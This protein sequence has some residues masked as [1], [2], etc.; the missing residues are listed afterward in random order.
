MKRNTTFKIMSHLSARCRSTV[1]PVSQPNA[2]RIWKSA[3]PASALVLALLL[4]AMGARAVDFHCAT[5]Q[6]LQNALT[7][8]AANGANNNIYVTN[9]Y[10]IG[11]FNYNSSAGYNLTVTNEP[12]V[13]NTQITLDGAGGGRALSLTSSGTGTITVAGLTFSRNCGSTSIGALRIAG[14]VGSVILVNGC[15]FLS[16]TNT[17]GIGLEL[18]S[19]LNATVTNCIV[20]GSS[21]GGITFGVS[22][23]GV[24]GNVSLLNC[25]VTTNSDIGVSISGALG[26]TISGNIFTGNI[27]RFASGYGGGGLFCSGTTVTL[28]RNTFVGNSGGF[29]GGTGQPD[30]GGAACSGTTITLNYNTFIGNSDTDGYG[31][32]AS[33]KGTT[34][35]LSN[36]AF[37]NNSGI[38]GGGFWCYGANGN[39]SMYNNTFSGNTANDGGG[40]I[41]CDCNFLT[42]IGNIF[43]GN[44]TIHNNGNANF[45]QNGGGINIQ[46]PYNATIISNTFTGNSASGAGGGLYF[47]GGKLTLSANTIIQNS[48]NSTGGGIYALG[49]SI[50]L[51]D[52]LVAKNTSASQGAGV[53]VNTSSNLFLINNTITANTSSGNGGGV[54][55]QV[56]GV[57][58]SLNVYNN[59]IWGN[60]ANGNGGDVYLAGT[61]QKK[62]FD[63]NDADSLYGV[64]DIAVNNKDVSP[65]FFDP[66]NG[67]YHIQ[68]TSPCKDAGTN[69]APSLPLTDMDGGPRIANGTVDMGCYEF[70][71]A[72]THPADTNGAFVITSAEFN[73]YAAAWQNGQTWTNGPNPLPANYLTRAGYL[74]TNGG[75]YHNDG[76]ARPVNWKVGP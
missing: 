64:W 62:V 49:P 40:G 51:L 19:G 18:S 34:L 15:Q 32:G 5:A 65:Q 60:T 76:S 2:T 57:V 9:G 25:L 37:A 16:P 52:N 50:N 68:S 30:A 54:A 20:T 59:I 29:A 33:C 23:S 42:L 26:I 4:G 39:L 70:S 7:L 48:A 41:R 63:F 31:G 46:N 6:D 73:A 75:T 24:I 1:P 28:T 17:S 36:N 53:W 11:N 14:G 61:G 21:S 8:A 56:S 67:D 72:A 45:D 69:A 44:S 3:L 35:V 27:G 12:G 38:S 58:E 71:T 43:S 74:M 47:T 22:I 10:Y 13:T 66:V 55:F